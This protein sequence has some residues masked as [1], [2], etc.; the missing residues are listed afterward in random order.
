MLVKHS[1]RM[2]SNQLQYESKEGLCFLD[3]HILELS[4]KSC[5]VLLNTLFIFF[6]FKAYFESAYTPMVSVAN[7]DFCFFSEKEIFN[8]LH[9]CTLLYFQCFLLKCEL[10]LYDLDFL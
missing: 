7:G 8:F 2:S 5:N 4:A 9:L 3:I 6:T 10:Q 1:S